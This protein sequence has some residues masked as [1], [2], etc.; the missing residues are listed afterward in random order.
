MRTTWPVR[1]LVLLTLLAG[2]G[3]KK[4]AGGGTG[5]S[6]TGDGTGSAGSSVVTPEAPVSCPPGNVVENGK[7][8][9]VI[10]AE[11]IDVVVKQQTRL[12]D[13]AKLLD[14]IEALSA[15]IELLAAF[16]KLEEWK[17]MVQSSE[18]LKKVDVVVEQLD[19]AIKTL[20]TFKASLGEASG[21][22]GNLKGELDRLMKDTGA[23]KRIEEVRTQV[24]TQ[25]KATM[26]PL[27]TQVANTIQNAL[28]PLLKELEDV[29]D[30]II[31]TCV[32][33]KRTGGTDTK[34]LCDK[35]K[36]LFNTGAA[37]LADLKDKPAK[38]FEDVY[39][40]LEKQLTQLIDAES[41]KLLDAAQLKVNEALKL[42]PGGSG[43]GPAAGSGSA[44][45][46]PGSG[47][48]K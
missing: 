24:S 3:G 26:E 47:S 38:L 29:G 15:P 32:I 46:A 8:V 48:A 41:K 17:T 1:L 27:A 10:T 28:A 12:D 33:A 4:D 44:G 25:L 2:C 22:L 34:A 36:G 7:C 23:A 6:T 40:E 21:R 42:P 13:M 39:T 11:K 19:N 37:F 5:S 18:D 14:K 45:A 20:R 43:P 30:I 16:R 9:A 35:A 31:A